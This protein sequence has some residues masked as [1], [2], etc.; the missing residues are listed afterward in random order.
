[1]RRVDAHIIQPHEYDDAP[2]L[3]AEQLAGARLER[4]GVP[5][6]RGRPRLEHPKQHVS[7]RLDPDVIAYYRRQGRGW[8]GKINAALKRAISRERKRA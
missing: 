6:R 8:Q 5:V 4:G 7:L 2:E 3:T 1:L